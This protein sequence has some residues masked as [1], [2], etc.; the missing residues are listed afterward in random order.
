[1][2]AW[3]VRGGSA[4]ERESW[5]I[6]NGVSG[7]GFREVGDLSR[8]ESRDEVLAVVQAALPDKPLQANRNF[9]AQLWTLR[10]RINIDDIIVMPLKTSKQIAIGRCSSGYR[11]LDNEDPSKRHSVGVNWLRVDI[12]RSV[13]KQDL[14]FSLGAFMTICQ[15]DRHDAERRLRL[16]LAGNADPGAEIQ[17]LSDKLTSS[18][19]EFTSLVNSVEAS[20]V[21]IETVALD[22]IR[23]RVIETFQSHQLADLTAAILRARGLA[24]VVSPPGP[25]KGIDIVAGGGPLGLDSPRIVVQCK[26]GQAPVDITVIQ[27]LQGAMGTTG[28]EQALLVAFGGVNKAAAELLTN[29]QFKVKV[30]DAEFLVEALLSEYSRLD[31]TIQEMIPLKSIWTLSTPDE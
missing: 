28:A 5:A 29:Q 13:F 1:M 15:L 20:Q 17:G 31:S 26:S 4:G 8:C 25:D 22:G 27:R 23:T 7:G 6:D 11:Y 19:S 9:A 30:W 24:C 2:S 18:E 21:D 14:L 16:V 10:G 12:P 3:M